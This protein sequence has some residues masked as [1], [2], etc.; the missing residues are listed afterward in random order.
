MNKKQSVV[1][2]ARDD[3][4]RVRPNHSASRKGGR[5]RG[6]G[7]A[8]VSSTKGP[9][10]GVPRTRS[11][12]AGSGERGTGQMRGENSPRSCGQGCPRVRSRVAHH[13]TSW[14]LR[15]SENMEANANVRRE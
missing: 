15:T 6:N 14:R 7:R 4:R 10:P 11:R 1:F 2:V 9:T 3:R 5:N 8:T 12:S 13:L